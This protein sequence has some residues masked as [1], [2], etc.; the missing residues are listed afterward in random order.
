MST[1]PSYTKLLNVTSSQS[2]FQTAR[3]QNPALLT[4]Q[5]SDGNTLVH[6]AAKIGLSM[7]SSRAHAILTL[8]FSASEI[9]LDIR[10]NDGNTAV[11]LA[12]I[13]SY[14]RTTF[15]TVFPIFIVEAERRQFDFGTP[16]D[17]GY[18]VLHFATRITYEHMWTGRGDNLRHILNNVNNPGLN[19]LSRS[20]ATP[21]YYAIIDGHFALAHQLLDA[22]ANP[23]L[24]SSVD[25][26][27]LTAIDDIIKQLNDVL[28]EENRAEFHERVQKS[29]TE[30]T[31]LKNRVVTIMKEKSMV[32]VKKNSFVIAQ[33]VRTQT[34]FFATLPAAQ[35]ITSTI[36]AMTGNALAL[37]FDELRDEAHQ[38]I[39]DS[40]YGEGSPFSPNG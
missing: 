32:E 6:H 9:N 3:D 19:V 1:P 7:G 13:Y 15:T 18:T 5:D 21:M 35:E 23:L 4:E 37:S 20:G 16:G 12:A 27:P 28:T 26:A 33:S 11:H 8:L 17:R 25:R 29:L 24:C 14:E 10:N 36:A 2:A 22:G 38:E 34:G 39:I 40:A 30:L 31:S